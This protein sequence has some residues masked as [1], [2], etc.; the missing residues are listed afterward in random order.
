MLSITEIVITCAM[1]ECDFS[2]LGFKNAK[3][4]I[5]GNNIM[6]LWTIQNEEVYETLMKTG[7]YRCDFSKSYMQDWK[8]QYD[9]IV[10]QMIDRIGDKPVGVDY[11]VWAWY[12]KYGKRKKPDLRWERWHFGWKGERFVCLEI[13]IPDRDVLL[14]DFNVWSGILNDSLLSKRTRNWNESITGCLHLKNI[15]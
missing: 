15:G 14:S 6:I 11:P 3:K 1:I 4:D 5:I 12:Q 2:G 8:L 7:I 10:S 9:W 13:E